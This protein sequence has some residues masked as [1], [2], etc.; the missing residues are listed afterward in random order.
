MINHRLGMFRIKNALKARLR[1]LFFLTFL[2][3]YLLSRGFIFSARS[4]RVWDVC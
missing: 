3:L 1:A 2:R 4:A